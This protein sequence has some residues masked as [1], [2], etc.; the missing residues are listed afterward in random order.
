MNETINGAQRA[1]WTHD[2]GDRWVSEESALEVMHGPI[3]DAVL[4]T[5]H[6]SPGE[7]VLDIGCGT[8]ATTRRAATA[9]GIGGAVTGLDISATM[10]RGAATIPSPEGGGRISW[11]EADAQTCP[12]TEGAFDVILSRMGVMFFDDPE[13]AFANLRKAVRPGGRFAAICWRGPADSPSFRVMI[14]AL[15][16]VLGPGP[17]ADPYAPGPMAFA[18][19]TRVIGLMEAA[20]WK[21]KAKRVPLELSPGTLSDLLAIANRIGPIESA[22]RSG[23]LTPETAKEVN[24]ELSE[25]MGA[26]TRSDGRVVLPTIM[27]LYTAVA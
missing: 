21:A 20:G 4:R 7:K 19:E 27:N 6:L 11:L 8:G 23:T 13:A 5:A 1:F 22:I 16:A 10:L 25:R 26:F 14:Q 17:K 24:R 18:D 9:V 15:E 3:A 12:F 2:V